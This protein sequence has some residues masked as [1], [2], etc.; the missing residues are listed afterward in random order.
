MS[1]DSAHAVNL[2]HQRALQ[3]VKGASVPGLDWV[4]QKLDRTRKTGGPSN[5]E[6]HTDLF[7]KRSSPIFRGRLR[8]CRAP[9]S[10]E[11]GLESEQDRV[12]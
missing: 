12:T 6:V 8:D 9:Q 2:G 11:G 1:G 7:V 10:Q 5:T 4:P 3:T